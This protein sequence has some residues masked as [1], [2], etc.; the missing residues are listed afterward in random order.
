MNGTI[1]LWEN[2]LRATAKEFAYPPTPDIAGAVRQRLEASPKP[3]LLTLPESTRWQKVLAAS[4]LVLVLLAG[5]LAVPPVRAAVIEFLQIGVMR[6]FLPESTRTPTITAIPA[7]A[8]TPIR[9]HIPTQTLP[10]SP[11]PGDLI[12][13]DELQGETTLKEAI[14]KASFTLRLPAYPPDLGPPDRVFVQD[15]SGAMV[16]L[17]WTEPD[18]SDK[19]ELILYEIA[20]GFWAG[21]KGAPHTVQSTQ[22]NGQEAAWAEGPYM[23]RLTNGEYDIRR[24]IAG[25]VLIWAENGVTYRVESYLSMSEAIKIAESL[26]P[27][28]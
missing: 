15:V 3:K 14:Q 4:M 6:I 8:A 22:V 20:A 27:I 21:E 12:A 16:I 23:L 1:E 10:P 5:L 7:I 9:T 2:R 28:P 24:I 11:T 18:H 19:A 17:V 13:L 26:K 25:H